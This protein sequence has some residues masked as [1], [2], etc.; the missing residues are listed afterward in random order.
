MVG[1]G[2]Y[3][4]RGRKETLG[5]VRQIRVIYPEGGSGGDRARVNERNLKKGGV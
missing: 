2:R 4:S 1:A 5:Y 3:E